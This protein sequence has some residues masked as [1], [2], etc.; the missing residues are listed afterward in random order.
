MVCDSHAVQLLPNQPTRALIGII[1][2]VKEK[3]VYSINVEDIQ[4][5]AEQELDRRLSPEE[6][7]IVEDK[8]G[9]YINWYDAI[10]LTMI[11]ANIK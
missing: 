5:V 6:V 9:D 11:N 4:I 2:D 8:I 1:M 3:V 10:H 7:R